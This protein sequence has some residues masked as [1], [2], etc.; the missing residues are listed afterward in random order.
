MNR[1]K[2]LQYSGEH[3]FGRVVSNGSQFSFKIQQW[4]GSSAPTLNRI[5]E[6]EIQGGLLVSITEVPD[7]VLQQEAA[8]EAPEF[9]KK[10]GRQT[11][12]LW[13]LSVTTT[14]QVTVLAQIIYAISLFQ[15]PVA[16]FHLL[17]F[18]GSASVYELS[19]SPLI[20]MSGLYMLCLYASCISILPPVLVGTRKSWL[21]LLFP[22]LL[23]LIVACKVYLK[24]GEM[25]AQS[26]QFGSL[27]LGGLRQTIHVEIGFFMVVAPALVLAVQ[28]LRNFIMKGRNIAFT[29][30]NYVL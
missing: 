19:S 15:L 27:A 2:I 8:G 3:G 10:I 16:S 22:L 30:A 23:L 29:S 21:V 28:G 4:K 6:V 11:I 25:S 26:G 1:G 17:W 9:L 20:N 5:V 24:I 7:S 13:R 18:Q 14:G 12:N